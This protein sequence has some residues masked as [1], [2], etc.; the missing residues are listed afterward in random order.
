MTYKKD[1]KY[2]EWYE[3]GQKEYE[4]TRKDEKLIEVTLWDEDGNV[5]EQF[6]PHRVCYF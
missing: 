1:G 6:P 3:N 2:T 5:I 4:G